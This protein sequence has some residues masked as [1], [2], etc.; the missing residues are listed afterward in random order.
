LKRYDYHARRQR[1]VEEFATLGQQNEA[2]R[3]NRRGY[4]KLDYDYDYDYDNDYVR[5]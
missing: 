4:R 5:V 1:V 2:V 3:E